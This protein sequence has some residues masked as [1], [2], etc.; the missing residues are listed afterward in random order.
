MTQPEEMIPDYRL[1]CADCGH[2]NGLLRRVKYD[3]KKRPILPVCK[4]GRS[5]FT[6]AEPASGDEP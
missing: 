4:C 1:I 6:L 3:K 2:D 5:L